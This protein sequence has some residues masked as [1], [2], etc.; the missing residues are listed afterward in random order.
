MSVLIINWKTWLTRISIWK[1]NK[2]EDL[3]ESTFHTL[4]DICKIKCISVWKHIRVGVNAIAKQTKVGNRMSDISLAL[5]HLTYAY[6]CVHL[7][8]S[9]VSAIKK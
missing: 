5:F 3:N 4:G 1:E 9:G 8:F 6:I 7:W 2:F